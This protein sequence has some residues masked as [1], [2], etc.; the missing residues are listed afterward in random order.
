MPAPY[1]MPVG[2]SVSKMVKTPPKH[3]VHVVAYG[4]VAARRVG[5]PLR[6]EISWTAESFEITVT[7][8]S[9]REVISSPLHIQ[10]SSR[11]D[12]VALAS[13]RSNVHVEA[14]VVPQK[15]VHRQVV[16]AFCILFLSAKGVSCDTYHEDRLMLICRKI[17]R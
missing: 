4:E 6:C 12:V 7:Y 11:L 17:G 13:Y 2:K 1:A 16:L 10:A 5:S 15:K 8:H 3:K 14:H 9:I